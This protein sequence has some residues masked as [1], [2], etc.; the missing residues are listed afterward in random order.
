MILRWPDVLN[1]IDAGLG[2]GHNGRDVVGRGVV[3]SFGGGVGMLASP[4]R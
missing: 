4:V 1:A 2:R 3:V